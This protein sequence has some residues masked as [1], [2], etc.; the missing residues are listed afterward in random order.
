MGMVF[1]RRTLLFLSLLG[2]GGCSNWHGFSLRSQS[3]D[4]PDPDSAKSTSLVG[5][6]AVPF[7]MFPVMIENVGL[8]TG[9]NG[10]GSDPKP[11]PQRLA[12]LAEMQTRNVTNPNSVLASGNTSLVLVRGV[13]RPGIQKGDRFDVEIRVPSQSETTSLRGGFLLQTDLKEMAVMSDNVLHS[14]RTHGRADGAV[15]VDPSADPKKDR[16][17]ATR[18][19]ILG[20]GLAM[21]SRPL[22]LVL[23]PDHQSVFNS[24]RIQDVVNKRFQVF[25]KG[26]I[27][28]GVA[29]AKDDKYI[30][31]KLHPRYKDNVQRYMAI[32][33]SIALR[34][35]ETER[36]DRLANLEK[37][38]LDPLSASRA[39]LHLEAMG[40]K[41][42]IDVLAHG[43][44]SAD[45]EVRFYAAEALAY[46]D[47]TRAA[48][49]LGDA[50]AMC[51]PS[52]STL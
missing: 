19:K 36:S 48:Q 51:P 37:Q 27:K 21:Q 42:G 49:P 28:T 5:D 38:L 1:S 13:I 44:Q 10:T 4:K 43:V 3:P 22:G 32:V 46:L 40:G 16:I 24:A 17:L 9:L 30:E 8:V 6:L 18:G 12:L 34:E 50:G 25:D 23:K 29:K 45:R 15:L 20:G 14:G 47:D 11:S 31:L 35:S 33:R 7:N 39:A 2:L 26:M 52:A 41:Q